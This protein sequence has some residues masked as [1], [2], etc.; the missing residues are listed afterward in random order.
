[1]A[2]YTTIVGFKLYWIAIMFT[3]AVGVSAAVGFS[4]GANSCWMNPIC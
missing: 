2:H 1:M 4:W 3:G